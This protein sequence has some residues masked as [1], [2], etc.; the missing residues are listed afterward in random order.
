MHCTDDGTTEQRLRQ[1]TQKHDGPHP[2]KDRSDPGLSSRIESLVPA[3]LTHH[4]DALLAAFVAAEN[5]AALEF[6]DY[7]WSLGMNGETPWTTADDFA[8]REKVF[9]TII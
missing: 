1:Q 5:I 9:P 8:P 4:R 2:T 7:H 3:A 6:T